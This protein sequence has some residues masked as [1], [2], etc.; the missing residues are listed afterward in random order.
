MSVRDLLRAPSA[1]AFAAII[2]TLVAQTAEG[3]DFAS[4][5]PV[6]VR[7]TPYGTLRSIESG[8]SGL[9]VPPFSRRPNDWGIA[10]GASRAEILCPKRGFA[11]SVGMR[12]FFADLS[13]SAKATSKGGEGSFLNLHGHL[14][15]PNDRTLWEFGSHVRMW[16]KVTLRLEY[17]PWTWSGP[18]HSGTDGNFAGLVLKKDQRINSSLNITT[19]LIGGDYDVSFAKDLTIGPNGELHIIK[20]NQRVEADGGDSVDFSRTMLQPLIG[21]HARYEPSQTGYFSWFQ[22]FFEARFGWMNFNGLGMTNWD[23]AAGMAP[24]LS[25]NVDAGFKIG[26]KQ[27]KM[28]GQRP[29][30]L[31]DVG[32]EGL[33]MDFALRF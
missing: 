21:A 4:Q 28:D 11:F 7:T 31:L 19:F 32:V 30:L 12:P 29:R 27:W 17:W 22:P 18:G 20:W 5:Y 24:P 16:D 10:A 13:G 26:Y 2:L 1:F 15:I 25:R 3:W 14:R 23:M 9:G 8:I 6:K 33:Y